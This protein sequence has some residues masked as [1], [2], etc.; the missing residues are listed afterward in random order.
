MTTSHDESAALHVE[1]VSVHYGDVHA[2]ELVDLTVAKGSICALVGMNGSGKSTLLRSVMGLTE[3]DHGRIIIHGLPPAQA[4]HHGLVGYVPQEDAVDRDF[5]ITVGE[6]VMTGRYGHMGILRR[7]S[8]TDHEHVSRALEI[9]G[10]TDLSDRQIGA[11]SGGQRKRAFLARALS[12][13]AQLLLLDEPFSG[14]DK[15]SEALMS[16]ILRSHVDKGG[17]VLISSHDLKS[18]RQLADRAVLLHRHVVASGPAADILTP[19]NV[20][21]AFAISMDEGEEILS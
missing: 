12:Q 1:S 8:T 3:P 16:D 7:P 13:E 11:L 9:T 21:Q 20:A 2:L 4:R 6:V 17:S 18:L 5:P 19:S 15:T 10:L 14:V